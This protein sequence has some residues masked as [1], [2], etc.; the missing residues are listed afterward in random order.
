MPTQNDIRQQVTNQII[1]A[2][3]SGTLPWRRPWYSQRRGRHRNAI[4][5]R[6]YSG[7]N[8]WLLELHAIDHGFTSR[9][10]AT[11]KQWQEM[12]C[13]VKKRPPGVPPGAWGCMIVFTKPV[14]NSSIDDETG[15]VRTEGFRLL[16]TYTVFSADQ[17]DGDVVDQFRTVVPVPNQQNFEPAEKLI[18]ASGV[19]LHLGGD[20]AFYRRPT[21]E[22]TWP[23]HTDGDFIQLPHKSDFEKMGG[24]YETAFHELAHWSEVRLGWTGSYELGEM[25]AE[26]A[27][28][29]LSQ[30]LGV[31]QGEGL[32]NHAAY[33]QSWLT[34]MKED[35]GFIF[36]ASSQSSKVADFLLAFSKSPGAVSV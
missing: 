19:E 34:A 24:F 31:P 12:G 22:G 17:V 35:H 36:K 8:P 20:R 6:A 11:Y 15:E 23:N 25:I 14:R 9:C 7:V 30:E 21:P 18:E 4:S 33:I 26:M 10:W 28:C 1:Q 32:H 16:R 2:I 29:Y 13:T 5:N 27:S 3:E